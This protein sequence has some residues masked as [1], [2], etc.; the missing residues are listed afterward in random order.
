MFF[1]KCPLLRSDFNQNLNVSTSFIEPPSIKFHE[2]PFSRSRVPSCVQIDRQT[3][4]MILIGALHRRERAQQDCP[5]CL[6]ASGSLNGKT[7]PLPAQHN[8][9]ANFLLVLA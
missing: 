3:Y 5:R 8:Q 7:I 1:V 9:L 2:N 6:R 4:E